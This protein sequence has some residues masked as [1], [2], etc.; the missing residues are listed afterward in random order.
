MVLHAAIQLLPPEGGLDTWSPGSRGGH[1]CAREPTLRPAGLC[2]AFSSY[3]LSTTVFFT[4][5]SRERSKGPSRTVGL[6]TALALALCPCPLHSHS[7]ISSPPTVSANPPPAICAG[8]MSPGEVP[9]KARRPPGGACVGV[10]SL[11]ICAQAFTCPQAP[12]E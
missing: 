2:G 4:L 10:H 3:T 1:D 7:A 12:L 8:K 6:P 11:H 9:E 5:H